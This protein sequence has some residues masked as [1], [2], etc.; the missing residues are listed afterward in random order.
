VSIYLCNLHNFTFFL[1]QKIA[2]LYIILQCLHTSF[3]VYIHTE[4]MKGYSSMDS[5]LCFRNQYITQK[6]LVFI[7]WWNLSD[8]YQ[9]TKGKIWECMLS[10]NPKKG[11][12]LA[13]TKVMRNVPTYFFICSFS[14]PHRSDYRKSFFLLPIIDIL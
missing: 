12:G 4:C 2:I 9:F 14:Y 7:P 13:V 5:S 6:H 8:F 3:L 1:V 10:C 11:S